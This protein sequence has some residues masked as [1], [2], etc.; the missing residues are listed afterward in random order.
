MALYVRLVVLGVIATF[1]VPG[2]SLQFSTLGECIVHAKDVLVKALTST[3]IVRALRE[4]GRLPSM[5]I[6]EVRRPATEGAC[7]VNANGP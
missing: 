6:L 3:V 5:L 2:S 1:H 7:D 4:I